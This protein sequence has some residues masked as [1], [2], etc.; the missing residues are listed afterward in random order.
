VPTTFSRAASHVLR[1]GADRKG[2]DDP[3]GV[4]IDHA[5]RVAEAVRDVDASG[6]TADYRREH[7][8][9]VRGVDVLG[10]GARAKRSLRA[11][12]RGG[13]G[14]RGRGSLGRVARVAA[15]R[16]RRD[17]GQDHRER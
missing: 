12:G 16:E 5:D 6:K 17:C 15:R 11:R 1:K 13:E 3:V 14:P 2:A 7:P 10:A 8:R 9:T 4:R